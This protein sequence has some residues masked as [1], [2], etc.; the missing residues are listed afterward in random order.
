M[1]NK[2]EGY[3]GQRGLN[4]GIGNVQ[5]CQKTEVLLKF[6]DNFACGDDPEMTILTKKTY[7][8]GK[9]GSW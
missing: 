3:E 4:A 8:G 9:Y 7:E 1:K 5:Y 2:N 6:D